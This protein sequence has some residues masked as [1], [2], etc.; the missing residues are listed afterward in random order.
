MTRSNEFGRREIK[1]TQDKTGREVFVHTQPRTSQIE[2]QASGRLALK[3]LVEEF[4]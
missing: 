1:G 2:P 4:T 3:N